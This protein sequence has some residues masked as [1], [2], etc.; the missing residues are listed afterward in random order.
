MSRNF[1]AFIIAVNGK[2]RN[3]QLVDA[4]KET[5]Q[6]TSI[7]II[8]AATPK[9]LSEEYILSQKFISKFIL[10][11]EISET[12]IAVKASHEN[13]YRM[14]QALHCDEAVI[15]EDDAQI[16]NPKKLMNAI[17]ISPK[18]SIA[19]ITTYYS[20]VWS[21][22]FRSSK[23]IKAIIPPAGAVAYKI[24]KEAMDV[25]LEKS[26]YGV[27][28]WPTWSKKVKFY[29][30]EDSGIDHLA[31]N[32]YLEH[33]VNIQ[34]RLSRDSFFW[35]FRK[36]DRDQFLFRFW[37]PIVW[38]FFISFYVFLGK[39]AKGDNRSIII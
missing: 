17:K 30:V 1:S 18:S 2:V 33:D 35:Q 27:A 31:G 7:K 28:D 20:P 13:V 32:S 23:G 3:N 9:S 21:I 29:L 34:N 15:F 16:I 36:F 24:N 22:W 26:S 6:F 4:L 11:R 39:R 8:R 25:A 12:E 37:F 10:G 19:S 5:N 14:A 38:K